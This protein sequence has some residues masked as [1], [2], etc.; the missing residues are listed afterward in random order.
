MSHTNGHTHFATKPFGFALI[1]NPEQN[2]KRYEFAPEGTHYIMWMPASAVHPH[3]YGF[4]LF[5]PN[6]HFRLESGEVVDGYEVIVPKVCIAYPCVFSE[7]SALIPSMDM[8]RR[9]LA[10][11]IITCKESRLYCENL[12]ALPESKGW[13]MT[14]KS[15]NFYFKKE[16][17]MLAMKA[18]YEEFVAAAPVLRAQLKK[19]ENG[20]DA[21]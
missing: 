7:V 1:A 19:Q 11:N 3:D 18:A 8:L 9:T 15:R 21:Y 5:R 13:L 10:E 12:I 2:D 6:Y 14:G 17:D 16:E 20:I 4:N